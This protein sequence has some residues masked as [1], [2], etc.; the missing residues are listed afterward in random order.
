MSGKRVAPADSDR[1]AIEA[2]FEQLRLQSSEALTVAEAWFAGDAEAH[3]QLHHLLHQLERVAVLAQMEGLALLA[4]ACADLCKKDIKATQKQALAEGLVG[5]HT[6]LGD[7]QPGDSFAVERFIPDINRVRGEA[8][9]PLIDSGGLMSEQL[10]L[11]APYEIPFAGKQAGLP[12]QVEV[13]AK[14]RDPARNILAAFRRGSKPRPPVEALLKLVRTLERSASN[15]ASYEPWWIAR[16]ALDAVLSGI[17]EL[18]DD[19]SRTFADLEHIL[20]GIGGDVAA[21]SEDWVYRMVA[22]LAPVA[23]GNDEL[24]AVAEVYRLNENGAGAIP[25]RDST[26]TTAKRAVSAAARDEL[27]RVRDA[28]D[29][30]IRSGGKDMEMLRPATERL[31]RVERVLTLAMMSQVVGLL[32]DSREALQELMEGKAGGGAAELIADTLLHADE[33]LDSGVGGPAEKLRANALQALVDVA[34]EVLTRIRPR[35]A[36]AAELDDA[37]ELEEVPEELFRLA[38]ALTLAGFESAAA[39]AEDTALR[40]AT[41]GPGSG[42]SDQIAEAL[43][44]LELYLDAWRDGGSGTEELLDRARAVLASA[45]LANAAKEVVALEPVV[46]SDGADPDVLGIFLEEAH[47]QIEAARVA[48]AK[49]RDRKDDDKALMDLQRAFHTLKGSGRMAG[50]LRLAEFAWS[51]E[52][53]V[54]KVADGTVS[55]TPEVMEL[56]ASGVAI[57]PALVEQVESGQD[58][59]IDLNSI[60]NAAMDPATAKAGLARTTLPTLMATRLELVKRWINASANEAGSGRVPQAVLDALASIRTAA[61]VLGSKDVTTGAK[62]LHERL[63][64]TATVDATVLEETRVGLGRLEADSTGIV[65][66]AGDQGTIESYRDEARS[67]LDRMSDA[68]D[69]LLLDAGDA[70]AVLNLQR[71]LHTLKGSSRVAGFGDLSEIAHETERVLQAVGDERMMVTPRLIWMLQRTFDAM[72]G[73]LDASGAPSAVKRARNLLDELKHLSNDDRSVP[74]GAERRRK[75]R[76]SVESERVRSD[77]FDRALVRALSLGLRSA[78]MEGRMSD[79]TMWNVASISSMLKA[80]VED[81]AAIRDA[82]IR[83]RTAPVHLHADRWRRTVRQA[84]EDTGHATE[85]KFEGSAIEVDRRLLDAMVLPMEHLLR[86]AVVH[87]IEG[88][89]ARRAADKPPV[90]TILIRSSMDDEG[91]IIEVEDD[92]GGINMDMVI[93][94]AAGKGMEIP[95]GDLSQEQLLSIISTPGFSTAGDVTYN[96]GYGMGV[97]AVAHVIREMGGT[98]R[99]ETTQGKGTSFVIQLPNPSPVMSVELFR[100][101]N[102]L[103]AVPSGNMVVARSIEP[104]ADRVEHEGEQWPFVEI[105]EMIGVVGAKAA[106]DAPM[107]VLIRHGNRGAALRIDE[108]LGKVE[109][110]VHRLLGTDVQE[111]NYVAGVGLLDGGR[112]STVLNVQAVLTAFESALVI[113]PLAVVADDSP[114]ARDDVVKKLERLGWRVVTAGDGFE[115]KKV[116]SRERPS[117]IVLDIDMPGHDGLEILEWARARKSLNQTPVVMVSAAL[118]DHRRARAAAFRALACV[119]KPFHDAEFENVV[120]SLGEVAE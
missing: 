21:T 51:M 32:Q 64:S 11:G 84:V 88:E 116:L 53:L 58:P 47:E 106:A 120:G 13:A 4:G 72:Y 31:E 40:I 61:E 30:H 46:V 54:K 69:A 82:L 79:Q 14:V 28:F 93:E 118:D 83:A 76:V 73:T 3:A 59:C 6:R 2:L 41:V 43:V 67:L 8:G 7:M 113:R 44:C 56:V 112:L 29:M 102:A 36:E 103:V 57:L 66:N 19:I 97:D 55:P 39:I 33:V 24:G 81:A 23:G 119:E 98:M 9:L 101:G 111:S 104:G 115:A 37:S 17:L 18:D 35:L 75:P 78:Q 16:V 91:I 94:R 26:A 22:I 86:N 27:A 10:K 25:A 62:A 63:A 49:Y 12:T 74:S 77:H 50:T 95:D 34:L 20:A 108:A 96:S 107:A 117:L 5:L 15:A 90:G 92:G 89:E 48:F 38:N 71:V 42:G 65:A 1:Q 110:A 114:T 85:L 109:T 80:L 100:V 45:P 60:R 87:G 105:A 52:S 99:M 68:C 70:D